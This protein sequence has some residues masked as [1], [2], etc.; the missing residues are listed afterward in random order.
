MHIL[1]P[2]CKK[3]TLLQWDSQRAFGLW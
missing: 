3:D 1:S 2:S